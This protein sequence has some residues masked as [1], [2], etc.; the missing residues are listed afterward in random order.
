[1]INKTKD[2]VDKLTSSYFSVQQKLRKHAA[3][4]KAVI[5]VLIL[6]CRK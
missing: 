2:I 6:R 3:V 1:M 4:P 5:F